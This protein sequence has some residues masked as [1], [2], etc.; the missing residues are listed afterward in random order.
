MV[1]RPCHHPA[2]PSPV[3]FPPTGAFS[4]HYIRSN[5]LVFFVCFVCPSPRVRTYARQ[6]NL[7]SISCKTVKHHTRTRYIYLVFYCRL[8]TIMASPRSSA[9]KGT[10]EEKRAHLD[11]R[12]T[13][14]CGKPRGGCGGNGRC[15]GEGSAMVQV[16]L[17]CVFC[18]RGCCCRFYRFRTWY[19]S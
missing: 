8:R 5:P 16:S 17:F 13:I 9:A 19:E 3:P 14:S 2:V 11:T 18:F 12:R 4:P 15:S 1:E 10:G 7:L 6:V